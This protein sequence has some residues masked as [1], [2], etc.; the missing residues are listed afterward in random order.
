MDRIVIPEGRSHSD[1]MTDLKAE[2]LRE[3]YRNGAR[4]GSAEVV[5][6]ELIPLQYTNNN[7]VRAVA[8][9]VSELTCLR[10]CSGLT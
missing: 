9:A 10:H 4:A 5:E 1:I 2:A 7:A 3:A 8:K 6:L